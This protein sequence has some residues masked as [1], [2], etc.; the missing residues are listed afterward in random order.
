MVDIVDATNSDKVIRFVRASSFGQG[1][2]N[3]QLI[4][5]KM[6]SSGI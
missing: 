5:E 2:T 1:N 6:A 3:A 4:I